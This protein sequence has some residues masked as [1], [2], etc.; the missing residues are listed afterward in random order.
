MRNFTTKQL[1]GMSFYYLSIIFVVACILFDV[2]QATVTGFTFGYVFALFYFIAR[3]REVLRLMEDQN[4][5]ES[6]D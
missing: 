1:A 4:D 2:M 3:T 6:E 5:H